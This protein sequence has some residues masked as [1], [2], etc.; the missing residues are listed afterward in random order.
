MAL[1]PLSV[2]TTAAAPARAT[3]VAAAAEVA[4]YADPK[5]HTPVKRKRKLEGS[6]VR[7]EGLG[8]LYTCGTNLTTLGNEEVHSQT[9][10]HANICPVPGFLCNNLARLRSGP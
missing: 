3:V 8:T 1:R 7:F 9:H 2:A 5:D 4:E 6:M 10:P